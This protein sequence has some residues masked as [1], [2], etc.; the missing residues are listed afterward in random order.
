[1]NDPVVMNEKARQND[2]LFCIFAE[3]KKLVIFDLDGTLLDTIEDL[4]NT[5][6]WWDMASVT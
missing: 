4:G 3:M 1:M 5:V 2:G 6:R